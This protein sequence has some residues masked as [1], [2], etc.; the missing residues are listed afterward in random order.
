M[1]HANNET[2]NWTLGQRLEFYSMPEP[3]SGCLLWTGSVHGI[4]HGKI[5]WEGK[6]YA[7]HRVAW[8]L[9]KGPIPAGLLVCHKC[10]VPCCVNVNHL[11]L[12]T[13][14]DNSLDRARKQRG[15]R[16][17]KAEEV[18]KIYADKRPRALVSSDY[19]V[20]QASIADIRGGRSYG[21]LTGHPSSGA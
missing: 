12:G 9:A 19:G 7:A 13:D 14:A 15:N 17:L 20:S 5:F 6:T 2:R 16:K 8:A 18:L 10:D 11:F 4:G 21:W 1:A 3:N